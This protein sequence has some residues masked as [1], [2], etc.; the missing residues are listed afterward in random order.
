MFKKCALARATGEMRAKIDAWENT[1]REFFLQGSFFM[2]AS[3]Q[4][5]TM[6]SSLRRCVPRFIA[7][8][9]SS[10]SGRP[11]VAIYNRKSG[12]Y[13]AEAFSKHGRKTFATT[14]SRTI[15][16]SDG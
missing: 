9:V 12:I 8:F 7:H 13:L 3:S 4:N 15:G 16:E 10:L 5:K 14:A 2:R 6:A 1:S 11:L